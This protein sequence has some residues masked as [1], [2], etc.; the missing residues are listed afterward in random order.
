[1][2]NEGNEGRKEMIGVALGKGSG[3]FIKA[4]QLGAKI[5]STKLGHVSRQ[6]GHRRQHVPL[7]RTM[8]Y[9]VETCYLGTMDHG[10]EQRV[11]NAINKSS[12]GL[13][14]FF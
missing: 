4:A 1:M 13:N 12:R 7:P 8:A 9:V 11:Q 3:G 14:M 6:R 2:K 5:C 10:V